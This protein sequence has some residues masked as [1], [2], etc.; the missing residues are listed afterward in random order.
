MA[1]PLI[2]MAISSSRGGKTNTA[3]NNMKS[4]KVQNVSRK[5]KT[6]KERASFLSGDRPTGGIPR[7]QKG[8]KAESASAEKTLVA[9]HQ[10]K[11][12]S[13]KGTDHEDQEA[14]ITDAGE[15]TPDRNSR[16][17]K[18]GERRDGAFKAERVEG[19]LED[20]QQLEDFLFGKNKRRKQQKEDTRRETTEDASVRTNG[21]QKKKR[22]RKGTDFP[23]DAAKGGEQVSHR[24]VEDES[25][26]CEGVSSDNAKTRA[27]SVG[28]YADK[29][30]S[31]QRSSLE[32][33]Q[34]QERLPREPAAFLLSRLEGDGDRAWVDPDD[35]QLVVDLATQPKLRKLRKKLTESRVSGVVF[36]ERLKELRGKRMNTGTSVDWVEK[37]RQRK[38][39]EQCDQMAEGYGR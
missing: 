29:V 16:V 14:C 17:S 19:V 32:K 9:S 26:S 4:K 6:A 22:R 25:G 13:Q 37:A 7:G 35:E 33:K 36:Q 28:G 34:K 1:R 5:R 10:K 30:V 27:S 38:L 39:D 23:G 15:S 2:A 21:S 8:V 12:T 18:G 11:R 31:S 20:I 3:E 24:E